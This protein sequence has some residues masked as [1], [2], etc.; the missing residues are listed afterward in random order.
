M[1]TL[2]LAVGL[3]RSGKTTWARKQGHPIVSP[4]AIREGLH[5]EAFIPSAEP[6]V[7]ATAKLMARALFLAGHD[8]VIIDAT[9]TTQKRRQE[10][11]HLE[12]IVTDFKVQVFDTPLHTCIERAEK[13]GRKDLIPVIHRM[14]EQWEAP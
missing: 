4:D 14:A 10:W 8:T 13:E 3:P 7:W 1:K 2:I 12:D 6:I 11:L 5:G 9:N